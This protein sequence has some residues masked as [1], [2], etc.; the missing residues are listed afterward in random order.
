MAPKYLSD[1]L[2]LRSSVTGDFNLR[3][4]DYSNLTVPPTHLQTGD[5]NFSVSGPLIWNS[6]PNSLRIPGLSLEIFKK[7]LKTYLFDNQ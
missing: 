7:R 2:E 5:H 1:K 6:L 3:S 4:H